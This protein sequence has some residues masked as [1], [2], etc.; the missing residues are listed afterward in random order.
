MRESMIETVNAGGF[1]MDYFSFGHGAKPLVILPG[2]SIQSVMGSA[3]AI[4]E[5]YQLFAED[6][7]VYVFDRRNELPPSYTVFDTARDT[8]TA[9]HALGLE[10]ASIVGASYGGMAAMV[11]ATQQPKLVEKM[12]SASSSVRVTEEDFKTIG[13]W[14]RL[15]EEGDAEG[16]YLAFGEALYP[17]AVYKQSRD[18]LI[19]MAKTVTKEE[20]RRF[21]IFAE[22]MKGFDITDRLDQIQCPALAIWDR[23]DRVFCAAA[24]EN[25]VQTSGQRSAFEVFLYDGYGHAVYDMAPDFKERMLRFLMPGSSNVEE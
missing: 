20:L 22:G 13:S 2:L 4:T 15:A 8:A 5:A 18:L 9:I 11:I 23:Q 7:T 21:I 1:T 6:Y 17:L 3:D 24:M 14:V 19:D 10:R 16:L 12:V 25:L